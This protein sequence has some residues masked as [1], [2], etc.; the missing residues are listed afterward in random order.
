MVQPAV[1]QPARQV[2]APSIQCRTEY[3]TLWDTEYQE[4]EEQI[5]ATIYEKQC[6]TRQ[7]RLCQPTTRQECRTE[8]EQ[9]C[10][11][12]YKNVCVE[13]Y[14]TE[15]E[16][17]TESECTTEYKQDCQYQWEGEGNDKVWA[18]IQGTCQNVPYDQCQDVTKTHAKQV[19][20][21]KCQDVPEQACQSV[22]K[23]VCVTVPD[24]V[25][26]NEP[27]TECQ[28]VP[29]QQCHSEHKKFPI[30]V[31]RQE[32]KKICDEGYNGPARVQA[33]TFVAPEP[34]RPTVFVASSVTNL[35]DNA[36]PA[37]PQPILPQPTLPEILDEKAKLQA[38]NDRIVFG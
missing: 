21:Q 14:K 7:Q 12:V 29:R 27:L 1:V 33:P 32:A 22:P 15:Y 11:T 9:Q 8:Y 25:C 2:A 18:P 4:K 36:R 13:Q 26:T 3:V 37:V 38:K 6:H 24:Q 28:D 16:P 17:Y 34:V 20:Y 19:A 30:R 10:A 23:Q 35:L 5:C 31:S